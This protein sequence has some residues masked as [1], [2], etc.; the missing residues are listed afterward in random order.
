MANN[1]TGANTM[2]VII[3][4]APLFFVGCH[5]MSYAQICDQYHAQRDSNWHQCV[6][7]EQMLAAAR[8]QNALQVQRNVQQHFQPKPYGQ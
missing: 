6:Q 7:N 2:R 1:K 4:L 8:Y 5:T 3:I